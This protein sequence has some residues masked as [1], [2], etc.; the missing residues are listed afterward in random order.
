MYTYAW[1]VGIAISAVVYG[2]MM[3][4]RALP[5]LRPPA[6]FARLTPRRCP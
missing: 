1:F 6:Q 2:L 4:G 5:A 3:K